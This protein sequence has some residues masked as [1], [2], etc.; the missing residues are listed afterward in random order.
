MCVKEICAHTKGPYK[1]IPSYY[2][3]NVIQSNKKT[4]IGNEKGQNINFKTK[5]DLIYVIIKQ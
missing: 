2:T 1:F 3:T 5:R 4:W